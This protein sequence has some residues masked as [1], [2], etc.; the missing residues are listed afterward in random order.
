MKPFR[1]HQ[2]CIA[3]MLLYAASGC[4]RP[5]EIRLPLSEKEGFGPFDITFKGAAVNPENESSPWYRLKLHPA[6]APEGM[7]G[8]EYGSL[9][10]DIKQ[11]VYQGFHSGLV[12]PEFYQALQD[13]WVWEPDTTLLSQAHVKTMVAFAIGKNEAGETVVAV[14]TDNDLDLADE[15]I[16]VPADIDSIYGSGDPDS[17]ATANIIDIYV[18]QFSRG[19]K[20]GLTVPTSI[21][22]DSG[23]GY[24]FAAFATYSEAVYKGSRIAVKPLQD[25]SYDNYGLQAV[26]S[27]DIDPATGN[28]VEGSAADQ[29]KQ[30]FKNIKAVLTEAGTDETKVVK[31]T[32]FLKSMDDF[33]AV[34]E[35]YASFFSSSSVLPARS[36][37]AVQK[38][39]KDVMV[40]V[41]VI[42]VL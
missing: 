32:V 31:A 10:T 3:L 28:V 27:D 6:N 14:D 13:A 37:V 42:A 33:A 24:I 22:Y 25:L 15:K 1:L 30:V 36:A 9:D 5:G 23:R 16:F 18:E 4:S 11:S 21:A 8:I 20:K 12:S 7:S 40:E 2:I 34:N 17:A 38:L 39:P 19:K 26:L 29:A 35:V 41:E